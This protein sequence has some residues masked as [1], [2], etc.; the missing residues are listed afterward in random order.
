M[1]FT[2]AE[3][4][5]LH[6]GIVGHQETDCLCEI[7]GHSLT[8]TCRRTGLDDARFRP[9]ARAF[10]DCAFDRHRLGTALASRSISSRVI[11]KRRL[12]PAERGN[13]ALPLYPNIGL[14]EGV[15]L[16][17][18]WKMATPFRVIG[19]PWIDGCALADDL[20]AM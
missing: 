20:S 1:H 16:S 11:S 14:V 2:D 18:G 15:E 12:S 17:V 13:A 7:V 3:S 8:A 10:R 5:Q 6:A 9:W 4:V 19:A